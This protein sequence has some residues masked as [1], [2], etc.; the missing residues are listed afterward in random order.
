MANYSSE[1][2]H[3]YTYLWNKYRPAIL[4]HMI[5]SAEGPQTYKMSKHEFTIINPKEKGGYSF[6]LNVFKGKA[7]NDIRT[8]IVAK[9]LLVILQSSKTANDLVSTATYEFVMD[10]HFV[11]HINRGE[12]IVEEEIEV[13]ETAEKEA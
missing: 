1:V 10:K 12:E 5:D 9:D 13:E 4:K 6:S 7:Q 2:S 8:S 11:L 3:T